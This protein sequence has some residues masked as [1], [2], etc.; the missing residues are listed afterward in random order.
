MNRAITL[1]LTLVSISAVAAG[2][3]TERPFVWI[4]GLPAAS[5]KAE[6]LIAPRDTI[7]VSVRDQPAL[8][9][10][11]I[12][13]DDGGVHLPTVGEVAV[14]GRTP[15]DVMSDLQ[16]RFKAVLVNPDVIISIAHVAPIKVSVLGEVKTPAAYEL[17]RDRSVAA[18]LAAAGWLTEFANRDRIFVILRDGN[19]RIRFKAD[20]VMA[21]S[22]AVARFRLSDGDVVVAE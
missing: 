17:T 12:V 13:R 5:F 1:A 21:P 2:C 22:A 7:G 15:L 6:G 16:V 20:Q 9:G 14:G 18:A 10:D 4:D 3:A 11:F 19:V 8:S